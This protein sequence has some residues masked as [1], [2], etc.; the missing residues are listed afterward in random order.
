MILDMIRVRRSSSVVE[1]WQ[2]LSK[3]VKRA[4]DRDGKERLVISVIDFRNTLVEKASEL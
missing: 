1:L 3:W 2:G 4:L